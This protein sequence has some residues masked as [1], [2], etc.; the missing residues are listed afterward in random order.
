MKAKNVIMVSV[1]GASLFIGGCNQQLGVNLDQD[2]VCEVK[3]WDLDTTRS[4]CET[5]QKIV[6]LP[7]SWGNEQLPVMFAAVNC[8]HRFTVAMTEGAVSC[9][10]K[11][12]KSVKEAE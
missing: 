10:F 11:P 1:V 2:T 4:T 3:A 6:F 7:D 8:D 12:I 9:I 5:G